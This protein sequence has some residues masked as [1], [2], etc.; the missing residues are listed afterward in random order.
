MNIAFL[1]LIPFALVLSL[2]GCGGGSTSGPVFDPVALDD[3]RRDRILQDHGPFIEDAVVSKSVYRTGYGTGWERVRYDWDGSRLR[4][5][6]FDPL[7]F[8]TPVLSLTSDD[9]A[10]RSSRP[11]ALSGDH[12]P[13]RKREEFQVG[14]STGSR[15]TIATLGVDYASDIDYFVYGYWLSVDHDV[16]GPAAVDVGAFSSALFFAAPVPSAG[17]ATYV[18]ERQAR[19][20]H[21]VTYSGV[22]PDGAGEKRRFGGAEDEFRIA[23]FV[24]DVVLRADFDAGYVS[25]SISNLYYPDPE[26]N[27]EGPVPNSGGT[28]AF[29]VLLW[30]A[31]IDETGHFVGSAPTQT[32]VDWPSTL[33]EIRATGGRWEGQF[34]SRPVSDSDS[35]P[36]AAAGTFATRYL[37]EEGTFGT[38]LG[39]FSAAHCSGPSC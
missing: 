16:S 26:R 11:P 9:D 15:D 38:Y 28:R 7:D 1:L 29:E 24:G 10:V 13:G 14:Q 6:I 31:P 36:R 22:D 8:S 34:S 20:L 35:D 30:P 5:D 39:S 3:A 23:G 27:A 17:T 12:L 21:T 37:F 25:G 19:G 4:V 2:G 18:G 33:P 32:T